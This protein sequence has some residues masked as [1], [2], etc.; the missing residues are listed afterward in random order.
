MSIKKIN[1]NFKYCVPILENDFDSFANKVRE[2]DGCYNQLIEARIDYLLNNNYSIEN[3]IE[4]LNNLSDKVTKKGI[5]ATIRTKNDGGKIELQKDLYFSYIKELNQNVNSQY[6]DV[7]YNYYIEDKKLYDD[8]LGSNAKKTILSL[9]YFD[10]TLSRAKYAQL[11]SEMA[12]KTC[13]IVKFAVKTNTKEEVFDLMLAANDVRELLIDRKKEA[14][15]IAMGE[16]GK[17]SRIWPEF[18]NTKLVF[19]SGYPKNAENIGQ[20]TIENYPIVRN[21]LEKKCKN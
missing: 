2:L 3:I 20:L 15:F 7:E 19:L 11:F 17:I 5:I 18:T 16:I 1:N 6:L 4:F 21:L 9:H 12:D 13:D 14:I 8:I 10:K